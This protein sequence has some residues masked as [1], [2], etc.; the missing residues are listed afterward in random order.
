MKPLRLISGAWRLDLFKWKQRKVQDITE[1]PSQRTRSHQYGGTRADSHDSPSASRLRV[2]GIGADHWA[3][4][5]WLQWM[6]FTSEELTQL[7]ADFDHDP[8]LSS[9]RPEIGLQLGALEQLQEQDWQVLR[10]LSAVFDPAAERLQGLRDRGVRAQLLA[11]HGGANDWLH[12]SEQRLQ[13]AS[14]ELGLPPPHALLEIARDPDDV[15]MCLGS[16]GEAWE[17]ALEPSLL[18]L[19]A[20]DDL[21]VQSWKRARLL[22]CWLNTC[23]RLGI[24]LARVHPTLQEFRCTPYRALEPP[25]K[26]QSPSWIT[27]PMAWGSLQPDE[28]L[29]EVAWLRAGKPIPEIPTTPQPEATP[30]WISRQDKCVSAAICIS[31][32]NY[33]DHIIAALESCAAQTEENIE[34]VILDDASQDSGVDLARQ[35][36]EAHGSRFVNVHLLS[37]SHNGGLAAARNS[38]FSVACSDWCFVL[39]ADNLLDKNAIK[40]CLRVASKCTDQIAVVHSL[41]ELREQGQRNLL[42]PDGALLTRISW[43]REQFLSGNLIDAMALVRKSAWE[44]VGGYTHI[45]GGWE[46][47]D[48]WCKLIEAGYGGVLCPQRLSIY[49]RHQQ[50]MQA[51]QTVR[52]QR[53]LKKIMMHRHPWLGLEE[54]IVT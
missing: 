13:D 33:S 35:W 18:A 53:R 41:V 26:D 40:N 47:F 42:Q 21:M 38:A 19:P 8:S 4:H 27:P 37:H 11:P 45:P 23:C 28:L 29:E 5:A 10:S 32:Y 54:E 51:R 31:L 1:W 3:L 43:Q 20:F 17:R 22:A 46:D 2:F 24:Q 16:A 52:N 9:Q 36:L 30:I 49:N 25:A 6:P 12:G 48:F 44:R 14:A 50:S 15:L 7:E 39:D 34:L